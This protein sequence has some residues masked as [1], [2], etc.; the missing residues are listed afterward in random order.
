L[1]G[2]DAAGKRIHPPHQPAL[3]LQGWSLDCLRTVREQGVLALVQTVQECIGHL[4]GGPYPFVLW[5]NSTIASTV[6]PRITMKRD[7][8]M[9]MTRNGSILIGAFRA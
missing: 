5:K 8:I 3:A 1:C 2:D 4:G 7:G 9:K 6:G